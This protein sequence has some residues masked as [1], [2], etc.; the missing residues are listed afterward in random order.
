VN[1]YAELAGYP[2]SPADKPQPPQEDERPSP[3]D[4]AWQEWTTWHDD[5]SWD[6]ERQDFTQHSDDCNYPEFDPAE[7]G[8]KPS[9]AETAP[10]K[11]SR[12]IGRIHDRESSRREALGMVELAKNDPR[13]TPCMRFCYMHMAARWYESGSVFVMA[14]AG[15]L[16]SL[17]EERFS[18]KQCRTALEGLELLG[19]I[20]PVSWKRA[21]KSDP[22]L[23]TYAKA[24]R[25]G[26]PGNWPNV[27]H[28]KQDLP[29]EDRI[30]DEENPIL[31][32]L[33]PVP[34]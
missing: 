22:G 31:K 10:P 33:D 29:A 25:G 34:A 21:R 24:T 5:C 15:W 7:W 12:R 26:K 19:Y 3:D 17:S 27:Y 6:D 16:S 14:A 8:Q 28:M 2:P 4:P 20:V 30:P 23:H 13:L 11:K 32:M 9:T 18:E 1:G